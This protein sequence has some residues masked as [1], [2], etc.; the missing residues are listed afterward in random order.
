MVAEYKDLSL[1]NIIISSMK[2]N[3]T[4]QKEKN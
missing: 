4:L 1:G 3:S 2:N